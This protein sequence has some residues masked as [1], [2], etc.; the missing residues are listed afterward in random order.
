MASND[1]IWKTLT[2]L[3]AETAGLS[4]AGLSRSDNIFAL[5]VDSLGLLKLGQEVEKRFHVELPLVSLADELST[6]GAIGDWLEKHC[7]AATAP[8]APAPLPPAPP[9]PPPASA[10]QAEAGRSGAPPAPPA[11]APAAES[12]ELA[13]ARRQMEDF[14]ALAK[15][16]W[17]SLRQPGGGAERRG[18]GKES[19]PPNL[20]GFRLEPDKLDP[21]QR[22]FVDGLVARHAAR[23]AAS[24]AHTARFRAHFA[25][26]KHTLGFRA[27]LKDAFYP[28]VAAEAKGGRFR[29]LDG[30]DYLDIAL[31]M[32]VNFLGHAPEYVAGAVREALAAGMPLGP[33]S[34][35]AGEAAE[36][37]AGLTGHDR[38]VW[39]NTGSEAVMFSLRLARAVTGRRKAVLF[40]GSYHGVSDGVLAMAT[41]DGTAPSS[42]GVTPGAVED[43]AVLEYGSAAALDEIARLGPGLA[44]VLVEPVQSRKPALQPAGFLRELRRLADRHGFAL[45]FD[46]MITGFRI[47]AGGAQAWF[48][49][50]SDMSCYGKIIGGGVPVSAV[51]GTRR[52]LDG[53]DGGQ[54]NYGDD[55]LPSAEASGIVYGGTYSRHPLAMAAVK[56]VMLHFR[57]QG[58][59]LQ[60]RVNALAARLCDSLNLFFEREEVPVRVERFASQFRFESFGRYNLLL[61]PLEMDLFFL[62]LMEMGV[63]TW[64][65]RICFLSTEH[66][67]RD[68]DVI[69]ASVKR[70]VATLRS[71]GFPFRSEGDAPRRFFPATPAQLRV[72]A[73]MERPGAG[74]LN[75]L[76]AAFEVEGALDIDRM[77]DAVAGVIARHE[78]LRTSLHLIEGDALQKI[79]PE[80]PFRLERYGDMAFEA[81]SERFVRPF[82]MDRPPLFRAA[83]AR[84][85]NGRTVLAFDLHHAVADGLSLDIIAREVAAGYAGS[86]PAS[87][88]RQYREFHDDVA[89]TRHAETTKSLADAWREELADFPPELKLPSGP[90]TESGGFSGG[91]FFA[92]WGRE[93]TERA[94]AFAKDRGVTPFMLHA[95]LLGLALRRLT[96]A[97]DFYIG[98]AAGARPPGAE[99]TVGMFANTLPLRLRPARGLP[100]GEYLERVRKSCLGVFARQNCPFEVIADQ[101]PDRNRPIFSVM[102]P[103][104]R[105]AAERTSLAASLEF[106]P[107]DLP[108]P[109]SFYDLNWEVIEEDEAVL[110]KIGYRDAAFSRG[111][112]ERFMRLYDGVFD[113]LCRGSARRVGDIDGL[114]ESERAWLEAR[115][116][117]LA[118]DGRPLPP[119]DAFA[120]AWRGA[121]AREKDG[122]AP[123]I[124]APDGSRT[125]RELE[126]RAQTLA[127]RLAG[128]GV[129]PGDRVATLLPPGAELVAA[130]LAIWRSGGVYMPLDPGHPP[131]RNQ[132]LIDRLRPAALLVEG[133]EHPRALGASGG[134]VPGTDYVFFT[135]GST[136]EPKAVQGRLAGVEHFLAWEN[137]LIAESVKA[138]ADS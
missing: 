125:R 122:D 66:D 77:E 32:G 79:W 60:E 74:L 3:I 24:K 104:E 126:S 85:E 75:H 9:P 129:K 48:G 46:E 18:P 88:P 131:A 5:G 27:T 95:A 87:Q 98:T 69:I 28:I 72:F 29:D 83:V 78:A 135:S 113:E 67:D 62:L 120:E 91:K 31:G 71:G 17:D 65:R 57:E 82:A 22:E 123:A 26:W 70:A 19:P 25:D 55:S 44:A 132:D 86:G 116:D 97:E 10:A 127:L 103:Y 102:F 36:L 2:G 138:S 99:G 49:V 137:S 34:R 81:F 54:W 96:G 118:A 114:P 76:V 92:R 1:G 133:D 134:A 115:E 50:K 47:H 108:V 56:A 45:I 109:A 90:G 112:A 51:A 111:A 23:T 110:F 15:M 106:R 124:R 4:A 53:I 80:A 73:V 13:L 59:A 68:V 35:D 61:Q 11:A 93:R 41:P 38:V 6:L 43:V 128:A 37:L 14:L 16:Q 8:S 117:P 30:N 94:R 12:R 105:A 21:R 39:S 130:A 84:L 107:V 119:R 100:V 121:V 136:G 33:Q 52:F 64:E 89:G 40:G 58:P 63:Y 20:R 101:A 42:A 7:G